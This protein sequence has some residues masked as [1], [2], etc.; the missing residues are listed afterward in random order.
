[1]SADG[2]FVRSGK[3]VLKERADKY[4]VPIV[5]E[6]KYMWNEI[7]GPCSTNEGEEKRV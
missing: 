4:T 3:N 6:I 2:R 5:T 1:M 7:V